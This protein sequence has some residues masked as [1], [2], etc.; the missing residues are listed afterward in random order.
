M[1]VRTEVLKPRKVEQQLL[2]D[3]EVVVRAGEF[4]ARN[5]L[6]SGVRACLEA[7]DNRE[8]LDG[9]E[10]STISS[11]VPRPTGEGSARD[12]G[13]PTGEAESR[14]RVRRWEIAIVN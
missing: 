7:L 1:N 14:I 2:L 3:A 4:A 6:S 5:R 8:M 9:L 11:G 10:M 12:N 13:G